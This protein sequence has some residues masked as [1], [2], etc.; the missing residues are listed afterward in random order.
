MENKCK[1]THSD[2]IDLNKEHDFY[3]LETMKGTNL[4]YKCIKCGLYKREA[5]E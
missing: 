3:S 5:E 4:G 1:Q 2:I